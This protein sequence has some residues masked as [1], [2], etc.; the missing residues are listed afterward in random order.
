[1]KTARYVTP[2]LP[3]ALL[4]AALASQLEKEGIPHEMITY[5][6]AAYCMLRRGST[7]SG[8][9]RIIL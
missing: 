7:Y 2:T 3:L 8:V 6:G 5:G 4:A 1:M 9:Y